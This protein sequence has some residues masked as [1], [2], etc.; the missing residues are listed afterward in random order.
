MA[1]TFLQ[2]LFESGLILIPSFAAEAVDDRGRTHAILTQAEMFHRLDLPGNAPAWDPEVS[3]WAAS[4]LEGAC[5]ALVHRQIGPTE[6]ATVLSN[7]PPASR[8]ASASYSADILFRAL[9]D[10]L[11][12]ARQIST[13]DPLTLQLLE[14][15]RAWPLSSV[16]IRGVGAVSVDGFIDD[17]CLRRTYAQ[18]IVSRGDVDRLD[19]PAVREEV[20][21]ILGAYASKAPSIANRISA[22]TTTN[23]DP[24]ILHS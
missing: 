19:H 10:V 13:D 21:L 17:P 16:G 3:T 22:L 23:L 6:V 12:L 14:L 8:T 18:R 1:S 2:N 20:T 7:P 9:G 11:K 15:A 4:V 5:R 24:E